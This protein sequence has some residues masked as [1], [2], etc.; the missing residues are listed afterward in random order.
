MLFLCD[1][2]LGKLARYLRMLGYD[3]YYE[4]SI[5]D[6]HLLG[7]MLS[8]G[9]IVLTRDTRLIKRISAERYLSIESD[10]PENQ[11]RQVISNFQ[12]YPA[13]EKLFTR[14][15]EC[16]DVCEIVP[17]AEIEDKVFPYILKTQ[18]SFRRCPSCKRIYWKGSHYKDMWEKINEIIA[19][20]EQE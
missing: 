5:E 11:I 2:N 20:G 9:R 10:S 3:T 7:V 12:L 1:D 19:E 17:P 15:L 6:N 18:D 8:Q 4:S 14:C 16:N 13:R